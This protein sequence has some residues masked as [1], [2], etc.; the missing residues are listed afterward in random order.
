[1]WFA[2]LPSGSKPENAMRFLSSSR[3][4]T[5]TCKQQHTL[6]TSSVGHPNT[7]T[8]SYARE[9]HIHPLLLA[10]SSSRPN[11]PT[12]PAFLEGI[13]W[14]LGVIITSEGA[15]STCWPHGWER[16]RRC[17]CPWMVQP[18]GLSAVRLVVESEGV[19]RKSHVG[20]C[21][22]VCRNIMMVGS[23]IVNFWGGGGSMSEWGRQKEYL[24]E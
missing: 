20:Y 1:M 12:E 9:L 15:G 7:N 3:Y 8:L 16:R 11:P 18:S 4:L 13:G 19:G 14:A 10:R 2:I 23:Q 21:S 17:L 5:L 6:P 22:L 24:L